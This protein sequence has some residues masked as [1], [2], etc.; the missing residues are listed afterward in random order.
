MRF[1][2]GGQVYAI[3]RVHVAETTSVERGA[4][5]AAVGDAELPVLRLEHLLGHGTP[6]ERRPALVVSFA[7]P[8]WSARWI[9]SSGRARSS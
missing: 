5:T 8:R 1:K 7:A 4:A 3:P 2:V 6:S 9:A